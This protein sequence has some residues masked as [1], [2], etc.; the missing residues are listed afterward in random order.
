MIS[1]GISDKLG[2]RYEAKWLV[3][4]LMDVIEGKATWLKYEGINPDFQGFEFAIG[5]GDKTEWHQ[6]KMAASK[7]NWTIRALQN[8]GVLKAFSKRLSS[9]PNAT[10]VLVSQDNAKDLLTLKDKARIANSLAEFSNALS[11]DQAKDFSELCSCCN[12][13]NSIAYQWL[14]RTDVRFIP[15]SEIDSLIESYGDLYFVHGGKSL[16]PILR[17]ILEKNFNKSVT[18]QIILAEL[19]SQ[20]DLKI[21]EWSLDPTI[22]ERLRKETDAYLESYSPF[23]ISGEL[24]PRVE[25]QTLVEEIVNDAGAELILITGVAGSGKSGVIRGAIEP[26]RERDIPLLA[27]RVDHFLKSS[28]P[29]EIGKGLTNREESP[30]TTLKG[31]FPNRLSVLIIDQVDAISEVSGRNAKLREVLFGLI[32]DAHHFGAVKIVLVCRKFDLETD[33]RLRQLK[34]KGLQKE[35]E[36]SLLDWNRDVQPLLIKKNVNVTILKEPC[37]RLLCLPV[38][39]ALF[40][41]LD[42]PNLEVQTSFSLHE[43]LLNQIQKRIPNIY[44]VSW[45]PIQALAAMCEWMTKRQILTA[46]RSVLD[47]FPRAVEILASEGLII[48]S[49]QQLY[50][51]HE[52]FFDHVYAR[53]FVNGDQSIVEMLTETEQYLF[54]RTQVR[55]I[56]ESL[57]QHDRLRYL[58]E[59]SSVLHC[60]TIRFHIKVAIC[61]WLG[62]IVDP[63]EQEFDILSTFDQS[64]S[65]RFTVLFRYAALSPNWFP[66]LYKSGWIQSRLETSGLQISGQTIFYLS[67]VAGEFPDEV[68]QLLW[69]YCSENC[70]RAQQIL[71]SFGYFKRNQPDT[72]LLELCERLIRFCP[73]YL[74]EL[75]SDDRI[76]SILHHWT[77]KYPER[78]GPIV[79]ALLNAYFQFYPGK[80]LFSDRDYDKFFRH[81]LAEVVTKSPSAFIEGA[82]DTLLRVIDKVV[83]D[84]RN[85]TNAY[86]YMR[87]SYADITIGFDAF[88]ALFRTALS[89]IVKE[90]CES[91]ARCLDRLDPFKHETFM[92]L[93]LETIQ[94]EPEY[95]AHRLPKLVS[96]SSIFE[97]GFVGVDWWSFAH[98]C[99]KAFPFLDTHAKESIEQTILGHHPEIEEAILRLKEMKHPEKSE[100]FLNK[101]DVMRCINHSGYTQWCIFETIGENLLGSKAISKYHELRRKFRK[102][103]LPEPD[104][105]VLASWA[106]SS[107]KSAQCEKMSHNNW[108]RAI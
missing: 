60:S 30:V 15:A 27:F 40:L 106:Q 34:D 59:L 39:L 2:N 80:D 21:K 69:S 99:R 85:V 75:D 23:G 5:Y 20:G 50:F 33:P 25:T 56:L 65:N 79:K 91:A 43:E 86:P 67:N 29:E 53:N 103:Q 8:E 96:Y 18:K 104:A 35:I 22:L 94:A 24:I 17:D 92:H 84:D 100:S 12:C 63:T 19:Q 97:A 107:I 76:A 46:P 102:E 42:D 82:M 26:L 71:D 51:F 49:K 9:D 81:S 14:K 66:L 6:T 13:E 32:R 4:C 10:C 78:C 72:A 108:L 61:Q 55:Q 62:S 70:Q 36:I 74:F 57:R 89:K 45:S 83:D 41:K 47:N 1:G 68:A 95:F 52:S 105:P 90:D 64:D 7:G 11:N 87:R 101:D 28:T 37:R 31:T 54:R 58:N 44:Q 38:N 73:G 48:V 16:F 88:L 77:D 98:A 93:H 3:R